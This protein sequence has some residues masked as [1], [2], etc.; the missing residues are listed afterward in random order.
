MKQ[1]RINKFIIWLRK[2]AYH[3]N[4]FT[5]VWAGIATYIALET[6]GLHLSNMVDLIT[7]G[8]YLIV[9]ILLYLV[10]AIIVYSHSNK[11]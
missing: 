5:G 7:W 10:G 6:N 11:P 1:T 2:S 4:F 3:S 8:A 9:F